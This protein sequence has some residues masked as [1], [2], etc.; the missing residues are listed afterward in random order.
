LKKIL[1]NDVKSY[2]HAVK[3]VLGIVASIL[4]IGVFDRQARADPPAFLFTQALP[5]NVTAGDPFTFSASITDTGGEADHYSSAFQIYDQNFHFL[6]QEFFADQ[7][8]LAGQTLAYS[9]T[10]TAPSTPGLY[11]NDDFVFNPTFTTPAPGESGFTQFTVDAPSVPE[12][13]SGFAV[14]LL[15]M[16]LV[17]LTW[18]ARTMQH[19]GASP[20]LKQG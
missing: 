19:R 16:G 6:S 1:S 20:A 17:G 3:F 14:C 10:L 9:V 12:P 15:L 4:I 2:G 5:S 13:S 8:F 18:R 7:T 11:F